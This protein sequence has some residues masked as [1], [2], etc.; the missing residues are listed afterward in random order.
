VAL[1]GQPLISIADVS[2]ILHQT[3]DTGALIATV[4]RNG[5]EKTLTL[6]LPAGWKTKSD[7]SRRVGT[8]G[9]RAMAMGGLFCEDLNNEDRAKRKL[10]TDTMALFVKHAGE[11]GIHAAAKK[12]GFQKDD[13]IVELD[14]ISHRATESEIIGHLIQ[15]HT[16]G[17][18][19]K[20][21]V[22][23]GDQRLD[24]MLPIQ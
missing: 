7:I 13:V 2:W 8:W 24:L 5:S 10:N 18:K 4:Q 21:I 14:G 16:P 9:M 22:L 11:Y 15:K 12:A 1:S 19:V 3:P 17:E 6:N 20:A 23:R